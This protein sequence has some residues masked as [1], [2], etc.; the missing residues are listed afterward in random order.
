MMDRNHKAYRYA[1]D[2]YDGKINAPKYVKLQCKE[3]LRI[4]DEQDNE[5]CISKK[6]VKLIDKLLKL[7]IMPSGMAKNQTVYDS[8]AGFQFF[9]I[10]AVLCT[11]HRENKNKRKY[12]TALLEICRKNG[13]T[14]IIGVIFKRSK[15]GNQRDYIVKSCINGQVQ[16]S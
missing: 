14:I 8:L 3:F 11:V 7:M 13:K 1:Q 4:A 10:I 12:E 9:L 5:F 6:K 16:N 15:N 2:V